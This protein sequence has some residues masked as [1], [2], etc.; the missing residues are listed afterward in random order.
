MTG[1]NEVYIFKGED[2]NKD[3]ACCI[4]VTNGVIDGEFI[5]DASYIAPRVKTLRSNGYGVVYDMKPNQRKSTL[6]G[7][8][9]N[10]LMEMID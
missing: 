5:G 6:N 3:F 2:S 8:T 1:K 7:A 9:R 4:T 10:K